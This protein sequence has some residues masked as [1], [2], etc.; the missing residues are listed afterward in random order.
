M[1]TVVCLF[2]SALRPMENL[3]L[4]KSTMKVVLKIVHSCILKHLIS[5]LKYGFR[6]EPQLVK[7]K[8]KLN[9]MHQ[10][11]QISPQIKNWLFVMK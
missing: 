3:N 5:M 2:R 8:S 9:C 4:R 10:E 1:L 7:Y 6:L 11:L